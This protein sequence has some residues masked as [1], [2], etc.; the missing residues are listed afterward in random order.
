MKKILG[1][2]C[3]VS[4]AVMSLTVSAESSD[5]FLVETYDMT[6][7]TITTENLGNID[8]TD[9]F[10]ST[11]VAS[12][13]YTQGARM[14]IGEDDRAIVKD[15]TVRPYS[16]IGY[17]RGA[18]SDGGIIKRTAF[19]VGPSKILTAASSVYPELEFKEFRFY[20]G[21][22]SLEK[23]T[24]N[25]APYSYANA[26]ITKVHIPADFKKAFSSGDLVNME[27]YDYALLELDKSIGTSAGWLPLAGYNTAYNENTLV[28]K[29]V[30]IVG[31]PEATNHY[32]YRDKRAIIS[33]PNNYLIATTADGT[34]GQEGG[35]MLISASNTYY[36][37]GIYNRYGNASQNHG[38]YIT[39][40]IYELVNKY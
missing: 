5:D 25:E 22:N 36:A 38:R 6:T 9:Y 16:C 1:L 40:K 10:P 4:F 28:G 3:A 15:T 14:I 33:F 26:I 12:N 31:Y 8:D 32:M 19:L 35:P 20:P 30:V 18:R 23:D 29:N 17:L 2:L 39:K 34:I 7:G 21:Y 13:T 37:L 11:K 27:K 24:G